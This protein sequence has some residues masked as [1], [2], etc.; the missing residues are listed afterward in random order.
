MHV[1]FDETKPVQQDQRA[2]IVDEEDMLQENQTAAK[3]E[4]AVGNQQVEKEIQLAKKVADNN[5]PMEWIEPKGIKG[6]HNW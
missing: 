6:Q 5:L 3:K 4:S 1:V 2:K